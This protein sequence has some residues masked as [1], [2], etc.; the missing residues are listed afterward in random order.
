MDPLMQGVIIGAAAGEVTKEGISLLK[1]VGK[2][3]YARIVDKAAVPARDAAAQ[4]MEQFDRILSDRLERDTRELPSDAQVDPILAVADPDRFHAYRAA[5]YAGSR[6][7]SRERHRM[8]A[9]AVSM[10][11]RAPNDSGKAVVVARAIELTPSLGAEHFNVLGLLAAIFAVRPPVDVRLVD[12]VR[13]RDDWNMRINAIYPRNKPR[14]DALSGDAKREAAAAHNAE[15]DA[16]K[17]ERDVIDAEIGE[18]VDTYWTQIHTQLAHFAHDI[19]EADALYLDAAGCIQLQ[20]SVHRSLL[21]QFRRGA[22]VT[23]YGHA[24]SH[25][26]MKLV[27]EPAGLFSDAF[28]TPVRPLDRLAQSWEGLLQHCGLTPVGLVLGL[29]YYD[30]LVGSRFAQDWEWGSLEPVNA[31]IADW[32]GKTPEEQS[33]YLYDKFKRE[34]ANDSAMERRRRGE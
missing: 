15:F 34:L 21:E 18:Y 29:F 25:S 17:P 28:D 7:S 26:G 6:T 31:R 20:W 24:L 1:A 27:Q 2:S 10:R 12:A 16:M 22:Q 8:L 11:L 19:A 14:L 9:E 3:V 30:Q 13:R 23:R 32:G 33:A 5:M 4:N